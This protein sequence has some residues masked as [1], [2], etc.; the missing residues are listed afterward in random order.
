MMGAH[1]DAATHLKQAVRLASV[2]DRAEL[3]IELGLST[4][5]A[6]RPGGALEHFLDASQQTLDTEVAARAALGYE[7]A[8]LMSGALRLE[9]GDPSIELLQ[10]VLDS[11]PSGSSWT[12]SLGA[13]TGT[14][15]LTFRA[16]GNFQ[17]RRH[18]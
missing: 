18:Q 15:Q 8:Y 5:R 13:G 7:D 12:A 6:G 2:E 14:F 4:V 17:R 10:T 11:Q 1:G 9:T 3:L 16:A